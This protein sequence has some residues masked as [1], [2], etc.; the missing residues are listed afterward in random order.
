MTRVNM[1]V[2]FSAA[3]VEAEKQMAPIP[4][5]TYELQVKEIKGGVT[6]MGIPR[7]GFTLELVNCENPDLNGKGVYYSSNLPHQGSMKGVGFLVNLLSALG[8]PWTGQELDTDSLIGA[9]CRANLVKQK[10]NNFSEIKSF[11]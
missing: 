1:G 4:D 8:K 6:Q 10:N 5:G 3:Q 9:R 11:V 7:L 2:D